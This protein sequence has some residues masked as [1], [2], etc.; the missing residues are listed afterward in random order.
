M[1]TIIQW[2]IG[3]WHLFTGWFTDKWHWLIIVGLVVVALGAFYAGAAYVNVMFLK[4][5]PRLLAFS[6]IA[7]IMGGLLIG[8]ILFPLLGLVVLLLSLENILSTTSTQVYNA[9]MAAFSLFLDGIVS[10][11]II[12]SLIGI[13]SILTKESSQSRRKLS[14]RKN[15]FL[16]IFGIIIIVLYTL[17]E[18]KLYSVKH[19]F[20]DVGPFLL[21]IAIYG[22]A[23]GTIFDRV[24]ISW[25]RMA[26]GLGSSF[27]VLVILFKIW[28][29]S[30]LLHNVTLGILSIVSI[31]LICMIFGYVFCNQ[32]P[33]L[34]TPLEK[35]SF[36]KFAIWLGIGLICEF[37]LPLFSNALLEG[38]ADLTLFASALG[39]LISSG[40]GEGRKLV[41][42]WSKIPRR[43]SRPIFS[44]R[45]FWVRFCNS[46]FITFMYTFFGYAL[47][48]C[49]I[50][51]YESTL[52][53]LISQFGMI[54]TVIC[55]LFASLLLGISIS[56]INGVIYGCGYAIINVI[57]N[58][59]ERILMRIGIVLTILG[60]VM[61]AVPALV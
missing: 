38:I 37:V 4:R 1:Y 59:S 27:F 39:I 17:Y 26:F 58:M 6:C 20:D 25:G 18:V 23:I 13:S 12:G 22:M 24:K 51:I 36:K 42:A 31:F 19:K 2:F 47:L 33:I 11:V 56:S 52:S 54:F 8:L 10:G 28:H 41:I 43:D 32:A 60:A 9:L 29:P 44:W 46:F 3:E 48:C 57:E 35:A 53:G 21:F 5:L 30:I 14:W 34:D 40:G 45:T 49:N 55:L 7:G 16:F 50:L 61:L 15:F